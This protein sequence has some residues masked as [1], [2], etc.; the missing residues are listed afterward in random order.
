MRGRDDVASREFILTMV[1]M[2]SGLVANAT[3]RND[4]TEERLRSLVPRHLPFV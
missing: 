3:P 1:V 4:E 2:D